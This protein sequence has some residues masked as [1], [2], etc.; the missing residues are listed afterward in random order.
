MARMIHEGFK[1]VV[2]SWDK[3]K[4]LP[5]IMDNKECIEAITAAQKKFNFPKLEADMDAYIDLATQI[6]NCSK[7]VRSW[8]SS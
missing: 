5:E 4:S 2:W 7:N 3:F 1:F 6:S 8:C